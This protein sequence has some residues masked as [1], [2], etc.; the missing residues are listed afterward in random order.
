MLVARM[1]LGPFTRRWIRLP[2]LELLRLLRVCF[3]GWEG[4]LGVGV[5]VGRRRNTPALSPAPRTLLPEQPK[6]TLLLK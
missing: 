4:F 3:S 5:G 1:N 2:G 6:R